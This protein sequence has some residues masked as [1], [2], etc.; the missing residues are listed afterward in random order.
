MLIHKSISINTRSAEQTKGILVKSPSNRQTVLDFYSLFCQNFF[1]ITTLRTI[2]II[3]YIVKVT[4][5]NIPTKILRQFPWVSCENIARIPWVALEIHIDWLNVLKCFIKP[6]LSQGCTL[7]CFKVSHLCEGGV[8]IHSP[9]LH[10]KH[11]VGSAQL[12]LLFLWH[13]RASYCPHSHITPW[14]SYGCGH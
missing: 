13:L 6:F 7:V 9:T 10:I 4:P 2:F 1:L 12:T 8:F 3:C 14:Q 5:E 11:S